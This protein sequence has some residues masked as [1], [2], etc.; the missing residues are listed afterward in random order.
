MRKKLRVIFLGIAAL[1]LLTSYGI[2]SF[3]KYN[4]RQEMYEAYQNGLKTINNPENPYNSSAQLAY[5]DS[6]LLLPSH[7]LPVAMIL[8]KKAVCLVN[9][10]REKEAIALLEEAKRKLDLEPQSQSEKEVTSWLALAYLRL[11]ERNNCLNHHASQS[12]IFPTQG[13]GVYTDPYATQKAIDYFENVLEKDTT[14]MVDRWFLNIAFMTIGGYPSKVPSKWLIPALDSDNSGITVKPFL[15]MAD[16]LNLAGSRIMAGGVIIDDFDNDGYLDVI[17]SS[18]GLEEGMHF[19]RNNGDGSFSDRSVASGLSRIKGGLNLIQA[20]YNNDGFTDILVLR[21]AWLMEFGK[22]P[23]S[24]LKNNGDGTFEDV[25]VESGILSFNPTQTATWADFNNDGWIDLFIGNET[26]SSDFPHASE[27][28]INNQDGT[29]SNMARAAGCEK[30]AFMKGVI[31]ADYNNDGWPDI[32]ISTMDQNKILLKNKGIKGIIPQF[33]NATHEAHLDL[34]TTI[35]FP[36]WFWD[37]D[38]DG[39]PDIFVCG[40]KNRS[41]LTTYV[42]AE[43]SGHPLPDASHMYLYRNNHD[44]TFRNVSH[45]TGLDRS[46]Y[47]MGANFGDIDN[48]GWLDMYLGTGNPDFQSLV[49]NKMFKSMGGKYFADITN[50]ARLGNLQKG[51]GVAIADID[52]DG[53]QDIFIKSGGAVAG[54]GYYNN[55]YV[56]PGQNNNN[57]IS[58]LLEGTKSNRSAIGARITVRFTD[59]GIKRIVYMDVNSGGSFGA[60]PLRKEIGIGRAKQIDELIINWPTSGIIQVFKNLAPDEFIKIK[61]G[62]NEFVKMNLRN[63]HFKDYTGISKQI[64]C[65]PVK[66]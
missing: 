11:G 23:N 15:D 65:A 16:D 25:T 60:N 32:F 33:V 61:E 27:L 62:K 55:F 12:C 9:L 4:K 14:D 46:V 47:A 24:L 21:G 45:E 10:G 35:T 40:Y 38:N 6:L 30:L 1:I 50:A 19:Y 49:P 37:F 8:Y 29:F 3:K 17:T 52:N 28:Y 44:G 26:S 39:W 7:P 2:I 18:W 5:Y 13:N 22:Q 59:S 20:D 58:V 66:P 43:A 42:A 34:D 41:L 48:D 57:W 53:D 36:T 31:S 64:D 51:H 54:D 63:T 56:N